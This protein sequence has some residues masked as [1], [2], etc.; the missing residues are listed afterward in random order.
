MAQSLSLSSATS[1]AGSA[2]GK[3][4][5]QRCSLIELFEA[6]GFHQDFLKY[7]A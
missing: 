6:L 3:V 5:E 2:A 4:A 7:V 1:G